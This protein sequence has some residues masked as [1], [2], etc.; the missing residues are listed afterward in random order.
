MYV[1][2]TK[3]DHLTSK[4]IEKKNVSPDNIDSNDIYHQPLKLFIILYACDFFL[5]EECYI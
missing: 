4:W 1:M 2:K 3:V 5:S